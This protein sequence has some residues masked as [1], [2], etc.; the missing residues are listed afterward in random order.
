MSGCD[1]GVG[2]NPADSVLLLVFL[3]EMAITVFVSQGGSGVV[4]MTYLS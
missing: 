3:W 2:M 1:A 4:I